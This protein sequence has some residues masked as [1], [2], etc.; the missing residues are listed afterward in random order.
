MSKVYVK[1]SSKQGKG[2]FA[3][4][5]L[6]KGELVLVIDDTRIVDDLHPLD[7]SKGETTDH[8]DWLANGKVVLMPI[9]ERYINHS[10]DPN[11]FVKTMLS[12]R[13]VFALHDIAKDEEI[14]Y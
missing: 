10:C 7:E 12:I 2:V 6:V 11:V 3:K 13:Y 14:A 5:A 8:C 1:E 4:R 9:P